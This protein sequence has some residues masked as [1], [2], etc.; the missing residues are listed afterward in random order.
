MKTYCIKKLIPGAKVCNTYSGKKLVA[1]PIK[2][3]SL[4]EPTYVANGMETMII[5]PG[6]SPLVTLEFPNKFGP[7]NYSLGYFEW[8]PERLIFGGPDE[9]SVEETKET[10]KDK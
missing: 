10:Q 4:T 1:V 2:S 7:G 6:Q 3:I 8:K 9:K 5:R